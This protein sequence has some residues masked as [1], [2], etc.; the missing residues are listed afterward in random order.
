MKW[1]TGLQFFKTVV[2]IYVFDF[3]A[4]FFKYWPYEG[5]ISLNGRELHFTKTECD[6]F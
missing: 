3:L 6:M 2:I 1:L 4:T 5:R